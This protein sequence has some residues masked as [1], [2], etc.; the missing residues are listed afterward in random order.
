MLNPVVKMQ[1]RL[2]RQVTI[3]DNLPSNSE[4]IEI[5]EGTNDLSQAELNDYVD[6]YTQQDLNYVDSDEDQQSSSEDGGVDLM[7]MEDLSQR[8]NDLR[9]Q[10]DVN[11]HAHSHNHAHA[12]ANVPKFTYYDNQGASLIIE[13]EEDEKQRKKQGT[14]T[15]SGFHRP[16][17]DRLSIS[18]RKR[19]KAKI[20]KQTNTLTQNFERETKN[21]T[22]PPKD[23]KDRVYYNRINS[24]RGTCY[25]FNVGESFRINCKDYPDCIAVIQSFGNKKMKKNA[26]CIVYQKI[27]STFAGNVKNIEPFREFVQETNAKLNPEIFVQYKNQKTIRLKYLNEIVKDFTPPSPRSFI[28]YDMILGEETA[29][30]RTAGQ[31]HGFTVVYKHIQKAAK[32]EKTTTDT[33]EIE[34]KKVSDEDLKFT[35]AADEDLG[36]KQMLFPAANKNP[37]KKSTAI[38]NPYVKS[39]RSAVKNPYAKTN[40]VANPYAKKVVNPYAK[41]TSTSS[42]SNPYAKKLSA[43]NGNLVNKGSV[44]KLATSMGNKRKVENENAETVLK[45]VG[46]SAEKKTAEPFRMINASPIN[47][48]YKHIQNRVEEEKTST[49][50]EKVFSD[51][52]L[53]TFDLT[54]KKTKNKNAES[55]HQ[56]V[57]KSVQEMIAKLSKMNMSSSTD[58]ALLKELQS[59]VQKIIAK[60]DSER[61]ILP[62]KKSQKYTTTCNEDSD[63][64]KVLDVFAGMGGKSN[65][66]CQFQC[67]INHIEPFS[68]GILS[69]S[70]K[71]QV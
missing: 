53:L 12:N 46:N 31:G 54:P 16:K 70:Y 59:G 9:I 45:F 14:L 1:P 27:K 4:I 26:A 62:K 7:Q 34:C 61:K 41:S 66:E 35:N 50:I 18:A 32:E 51:E 15:Q 24:A 52:H 29:S 40:K 11:A 20:E 17:S 67:I 69:H 19:K 71:I 58:S 42:T 8:T 2:C 43:S 25:V 47:S 64:I 65:F 10:D 3:Q 13:E 6:S 33:M 28:E 60:A 36:S 5:E 38:A 23:T 63:K 56:L 55:A 68:F 57:V 30:F 44:S 22:S 21:K 49:D 48:R 37:Y 39:T